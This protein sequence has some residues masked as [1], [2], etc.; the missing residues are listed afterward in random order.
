MIDSVQC[1]GELTT[2]SAVTLDCDVDGEVQSVTRFCAGTVV[3]DGTA[4]SSSNGY[5][6]LFNVHPK[7]SAS[8]KMLT[9]LSRMSVQGCIY[10]I[11]SVKG[12]L[13]VAKDT[14]VSPIAE[15][16]NLHGS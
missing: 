8:G 16:G 5:L 6:L 2:L 10:A 13:A 3:Y 12:M 7:E 9:V 4:Q 11:R 1:K 14:S 15:E